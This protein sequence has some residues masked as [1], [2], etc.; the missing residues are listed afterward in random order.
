MINFESQIYALLL[1]VLTVKYLYM[2][3]IHR[4][5]ESQQNN[6]RGALCYFWAA[7]NYDHYI[8]ENYGKPCENREC[9]TRE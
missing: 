8:N 4:H 1:A 2:S 5:I 9:T 3:R 6:L 7:Y